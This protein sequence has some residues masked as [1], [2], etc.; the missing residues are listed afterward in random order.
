[1]ISLELIACYTN[2][3]YD[4]A[5]AMHSPMKLTQKFADVLQ[6]VL[7]KVK[8]E[9]SMNFPAIPLGYQQNMRHRWVSSD[10]F[11]S[12]HQVSTT[13]MSALEE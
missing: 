10:H 12:S 8:K 4:Q 7:A 1:M 9:Y 13:H 6:A 11:N 3:G 2:F 5:V